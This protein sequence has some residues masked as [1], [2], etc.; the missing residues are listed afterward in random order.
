V[1]RCLTN[2]SERS[3]T[4]NS[5]DPKPIGDCQAEPETSTDEAEEADGR[6][7]AVATVM[8]VKDPD[9]RLGRA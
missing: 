6:F 5:S 1:R 2:R 3:R 4:P 7:D 9:R 8:R